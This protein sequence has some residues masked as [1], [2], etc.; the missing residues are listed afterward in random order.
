MARNTSSAG[1]IVPG[2]PTPKSSYQARL[3]AVA[4]GIAS[5]GLG[6]DYAA[7]A[8]SAQDIGRFLETCRGG[9]VQLQIAEPM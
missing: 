8:T 5:G 3:G 4:S 7:V 6:S 9:G 2:A 1:L